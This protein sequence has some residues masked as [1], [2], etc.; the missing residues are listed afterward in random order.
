MKQ[1]YLLTGRPGTGKTSLIKQAVAEVTIKAGGFY[2]EEIRSQG[3]RQGFRLVALDGQSTI[4][5]HIEIQSPYHVGKYGVDIN[6][7]DR[8]GVSALKQAAQQCEL[9]II[10]E[11]GRMELFSTNFREVV[12]Q[13]I[14]SGRR[15][16][17]T[18]MLNPNPWA[19]AIKRYP[20]VEL[21]PVNRNNYNQVLAEL[22]QWLKA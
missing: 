13:I 22:Q 12:L 15:L 1:V 7:L 2:T 3:I 6:A 4:L 10:D 18:I 9:V 14:D 20:Q 19:D 8:V 16:L 11:I 21:V 17:G 5:A